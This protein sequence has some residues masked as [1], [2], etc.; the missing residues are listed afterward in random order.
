VHKHGKEERDMNNFK[1]KLLALVLVLA[2]ALG[3]AP[4]AVQA[5]VSAPTDVTYYLTSKDGGS[6]ETIYIDGLSKSSKVS[7]IKSSDKSVVTLDSYQK[8]SYTGSSTTTYLNSESEGYSNSYKDYSA[9]I[10]FILNKAG[11]TDITYTIGKKS[12]TTTITVKDYTNPLK[13]VEISGLKNGKSSN[14][15]GLVDSSSTA[16]ALN[17]KSDQ[18]NAKIKL[19]AKK[20]W[21][22]VSAEL[23]DNDTSTSVQMFNYAGGLS[24]V[25]LLS[26]TLK[27]D[28][29]YQLYIYLYHEEDGGSMYITYTIN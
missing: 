11:T 5:A 2:T 17:L 6:Y 22:I 12:Y 21:K 23:H 27:K 4:L 19:A 28:E 15:K 10:G 29:S 3:S 20:G 1:T 9:Y 18:K 14:L 24:S 13:T 8:S 7:K 26:G 16:S 25:T